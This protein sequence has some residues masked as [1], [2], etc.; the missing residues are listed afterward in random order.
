MERRNKS[1]AQKKTTRNHQRSKA[2]YRNRKF[3]AW[4]QK[5]LKKE[6]FSTIS[7]AGLLINSFG[8]YLDAF[9]ES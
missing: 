9:C 6:L 4:L 7:G 1:S 8:I 5:E 3:G 2:P